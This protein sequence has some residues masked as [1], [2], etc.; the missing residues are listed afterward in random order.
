MFGLLILAV[1]TFSNEVANS[2][3]KKA[4]QKKEESVYTMGFLHTFWA[5]LFILVLAFIVPKDFFIEGFPGGF[6][7]SLA[8]LPT[9]IPRLVLEIVQL[10]VSLFAI[11]R[12]D[13]STFSFLGIITIPLLL[14]VDILLGYP[15]STI[16]LAGITLIF[17]SLLILFANHGIRRKGMFLVI[18]SAINAVITVS[19]YKYNISNFNSVEA[20]QGIILLALLVYTYLLA[21]KRCGENPLVFFLRPLFLF[22]SIIKGFGGVLISFAFLFAPASIIMAGKRSFTIIWSIISGNIYFKEKRLAVKI[23]GFLLITTGII[24]VAM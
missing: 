22:Q 11:T 13:R 18:F 21:N 6:T 12:A 15:I 17:I 20:E 1:A 9:F 16:Q 3:G 7:F 23:V 24:L 4:V 14:F 8:S 19:L 5:T 10:H 2:I